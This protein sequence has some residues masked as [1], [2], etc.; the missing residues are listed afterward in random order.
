[1]FVWYSTW[2]RETHS[3]FWYILFL[4]CCRFDYLRA[5][6]SL[7]KRG[8][9][10]TWFWWHG[11]SLVKMEMSSNQNQWPQYFKEYY[12][13]NFTLLT[14]M[15]G[16]MITLSSVSVLGPLLFSSH[17]LEFHSQ[18]GKKGKHILQFSVCFL[19]QIKP[20]NIV[21]MTL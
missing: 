6:Y 7:C 2:K 14:V 13:N 3:H 15:F 12:F 18:A 16:W 19:I 10:R 9:Y 17:I 5:P 4:F 1:M 20:V 11:N 8:K 21:V